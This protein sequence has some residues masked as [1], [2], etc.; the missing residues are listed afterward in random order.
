M[1]GETSDVIISIIYAAKQ[2]KVNFPFNFIYV[3][4]FWR[5]IFGF[6]FFLLFPLESLLFG[7]TFFFEIFAQSRAC[8]NIAG[9]MQHKGGTRA[10][11]DTFVHVLFSLKETRFQKICENDTFS[12][13]EWR[14]CCVYFV[15]PV[16]VLNP[17]SSHMSRRIRSK[18]THHCDA[19]T[20]SAWRFD[21]F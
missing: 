12:L 4:L 5:S 19:K 17:K 10:E 20:A 15:N 2:E 9:T 1:R 8:A 3:L 18:F 21:R 14:R 6:T 7:F 13:K 11:R 16:R